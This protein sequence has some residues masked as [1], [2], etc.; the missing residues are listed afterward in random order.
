MDMG[1]V[2]AIAVLLPVLG[3]AALAAQ[4]KGNNAGDK[5]K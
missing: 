3:S 4:K 2:G 1:T 5:K